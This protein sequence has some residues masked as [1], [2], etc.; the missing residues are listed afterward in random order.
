[1]RIIGVDFTSAPRRVK[2][3][4]A[5]ECVLADGRLSFLRMHRWPDFAAF[6]AALVAPGPWVMGLDF[7]FGQSRRFIK[8][9]GWPLDWAAYVTHVATLSRAEFREVLTAYRLP[10]ATGDRE[11]QRGI[12]RHTGGISP[13]KLHGVPVALMFF[14]GA[15]RLLEAGVNLPLLKAGDPERVALEAYPG[16]LARALIGRRSYKN[17]AR[18]KQTPALAAA[19]RDLLLALTGPA[20][21]RAHGL[22]VDAPALLAEDATGDELDALLCAVQAAWA[23]QRRASNY[24]L[25]ADADPLEGWICGPHCAL[26]GTL[27][28]PFSA[29]DEIPAAA[30][31]SAL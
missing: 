21:E 6:E 22:A 27:L 12:D 2:P 11:H 7:P 3:I 15:R 1:M 8:N 17:D 16:V 30:A 19:R 14:E 25:P 31:K 29:P 18:R 26:S 10:R 23:F 13:Q 4:T 5:A 24:A 20:F 9:I 28:P